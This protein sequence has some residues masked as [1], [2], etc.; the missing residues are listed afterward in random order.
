MKTA[1]TAEHL[2]AMDGGGRRA[3]N[4]NCGAILSQGVRRDNNRRT[5]YNRREVILTLNDSLIIYK[6][7]L[8]N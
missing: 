2:A 8:G 5:C 1:P 6:R 3:G 4:K 7:F